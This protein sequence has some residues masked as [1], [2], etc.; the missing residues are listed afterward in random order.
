MSVLRGAFRLSVVVALVVVSQGGPAIA[1]TTLL[2]LS[3]VQTDQR[4]YGAT[5]VF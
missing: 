4:R 3:H 5:E 2:G 1:Q